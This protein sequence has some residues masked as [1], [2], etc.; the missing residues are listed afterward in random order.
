MTAA[1]YLL[2]IT[3]GIFLP[4]PPKRCRRDTGAPPSVPARAG[5][6]LYARDVGSFA[7]LGQIDSRLRHAAVPTAE[8]AIS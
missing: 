3:L 8:S 1:E 5:L 6:F 7:Q 2:P 4:P